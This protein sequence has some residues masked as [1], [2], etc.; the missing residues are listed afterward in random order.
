MQLLIKK[1]RKERGMSLRELA[2]LTGISKTQLNDMERGVKHI[3]LLK[4]AKIATHLNVCTKALFVNCYGVK[5]CCDFKC[6][7]CCSLRHKNFYKKKE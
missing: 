1:Y 3:D 6:R 2:M 5:K 4:L 7:H